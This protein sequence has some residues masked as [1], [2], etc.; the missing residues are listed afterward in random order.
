[1]MVSNCGACKRLE[2][3]NHLQMI[4]RV[5]NQFIQRLCGMEISSVWVAFRWILFFILMNT[6][7]SG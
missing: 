5:S 6:F 7:I 4:A 2:S 3:I 1:M